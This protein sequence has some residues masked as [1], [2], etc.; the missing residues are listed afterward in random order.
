MQGTHRI[1]QHM[2]LG[3]SAGLGLRGWDDR[4]IKGSALGGYVA[5]TA[6]EGDP[7]SVWGLSLKRHMLYAS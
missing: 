3:I 4:H 7:V 5:V 2:G 6:Y 1:V